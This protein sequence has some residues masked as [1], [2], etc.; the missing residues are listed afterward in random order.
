M[1]KAES[2]LS[3]LDEKRSKLIDLINQDGETPVPTSDMSEVMLQLAIINEMLG[4]HVVIAKGQQI[5]AEEKAW[6]DSLEKTA[7]AKAQDVRY[8][9]VGER[10]NFELLHTKHAD[11][12]K[13][14]N[15]AQTHLKNKPE[16]VK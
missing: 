9:T 1:S 8:K 10:E 13:L 16:E 5:R 12:W 14:L 15:I 4:A 11:T 3:E 6:N 2:L 7:T